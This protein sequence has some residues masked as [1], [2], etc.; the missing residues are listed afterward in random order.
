MTLGIMQSVRLPSVIYAEC[1]IKA[2]NPECQY[3]ECCYSECRYAGCRCAA[4]A[5]LGF[6]NK[7]FH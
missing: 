6:E 2:L 1:H 5:T 4:S 3:A 7:K